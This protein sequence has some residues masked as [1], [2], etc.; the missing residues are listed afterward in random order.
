MKDKGKSLPCTNAISQ[1]LLT[2]GRNKGIVERTDERQTVAH[3]GNQLEVGGLGEPD[4][5]TRRETGG[6]RLV[7]VTQDARTRELRY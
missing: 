5:V 3:A 1:S 6:T 4:G 2:V 7:P